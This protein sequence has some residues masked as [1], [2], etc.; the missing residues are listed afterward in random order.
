MKNSTFLYVVTTVVTALCCLTTIAIGAEQSSPEQ[1][2]IIVMEQ[3]VEKVS[4]P[5]VTLRNRTGEIEPANFYGGS[6]GKLEAGFCT[7]AFSPIWG[8]ED[9]AQSIPFYI[10]DEKIELVT[11]QEASKIRVILF[12][13]SM[14]IILILKRVA[15]A[16]PCSTERSDWKND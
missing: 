6:R 16:V 14:A 1:E 15:A 5:F 9:I 11:I 7:V 4:V 10:P 12:S 3:K 8:L 2:E 13:I